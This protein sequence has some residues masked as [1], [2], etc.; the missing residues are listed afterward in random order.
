MA[1]NIAPGLSGLDRAQVRHLVEGGHS[2]LTDDYEAVLL[3]EHTGW[4][5][6]QVLDR[7]GAPGDHTRFRRRGH[8]TSGRILAAR[9]GGAHGPGGRSHRR[10]QVVGTPTYKVTFADLLTSVEKAYG[11]DT[12]PVFESHPVP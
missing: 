4:T 6:E 12:A 8:R 9:R 2:L 7:T 10:G 1:D 5:R 3:L 11:A